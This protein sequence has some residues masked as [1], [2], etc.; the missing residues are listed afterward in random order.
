MSGNG[1]ERLTQQAQGVTV[2]AGATLAAQGA[3]TMQV[4]GRYKE[5]NAVPQAF[6]LDGKTCETYVSSRPGEPSQPVQHLSD[7][8]TRLGPAPTAATPIPGLS[9]A[10]NG[11][12][13]PIPV[14]ST[15]TGPVKAS[16]S[17]STGTSSSASTSASPTVST[18]PSGPGAKPPSGNSDPVSSEPTTN[19]STESELDPPPGGSGGAVVTTDPTDTE[20]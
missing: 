3:K 12:V 17:P 18:D 14:T 11:V 2:T 9:T 19:A 6:Q 13:I 15:S 1:K 7:G 4:T 8:T 5:S 16:Q 10:P 20:E